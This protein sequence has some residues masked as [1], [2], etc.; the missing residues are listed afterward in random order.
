MAASDCVPPM[1]PRPMNMDPSLF[2]SA[3]SLVF[4][5]FLPA[6]LSVFAHRNHGQRVQSSSEKTAD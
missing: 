3:N 6:T 1:F 2:L 4:L 5:H